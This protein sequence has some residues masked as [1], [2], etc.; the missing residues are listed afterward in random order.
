VPASDLIFALV[1][2]HV[3]R[4][5]SEYTLSVAW[6][7]NTVPVAATPPKVNFPVYKSVLEI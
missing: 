1:K 7:F 2:F 6:L 4:I 5:Y 3:P